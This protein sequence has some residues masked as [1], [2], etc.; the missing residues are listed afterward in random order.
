MQCLPTVFPLFAVFYCSFCLGI[1]HQPSAKLLLGGFLGCVKVG[2]AKRAS[3]F[4][5]HVDF[6]VMFIL[7]SC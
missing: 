4:E 3:H 5:G 7:R 1:R 2:G 6:Q